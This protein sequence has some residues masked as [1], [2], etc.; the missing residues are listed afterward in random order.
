MQVRFWGTRGSIPSPGSHTVRYGGNTSCVE[1]IAADGTN[2]I[3]DCGTG[4]RELGQQLLSRGP[5]ALRLHLFIGHTH[6]DHIQGFPFFVPAFLPGTELNIYAPAGFQRSLEDSMAGQMQYSYF[7]VRF[8]DLQ[9]RIHFTDLGEGFF[10]VGELLVETLHLNHTV[11]TIAYRITGDGAT[12]AYVTDHE[13][14]WKSDGDR[15]RHPGDLRHIGFLKDAD[16]VIHD[17]QYTEEEYPQRIGWGHSTVEYATDVA[18]AAGA[19]RL[20]LFHH[21]PNR[22]DG[23]IEKLEALARDRVSARGSG[24]EVFA[25]AEGLILDVAGGIGQAP[26]VT[27]LSAL[28]RR[29]IAG[30]RVLVV[31]SIASDV[32]AIIQQLEEDHLVLTRS[33]TLAVALAQARETPPDLVIV[34]ADLPDS[35]GV[36]HIERLRDWSARESLPLLLL[37]EGPNIEL[38]LRAS[39]PAID[40][41]VKPFSPAML[42]ARVRAWL[43]RA[44]DRDDAAASDRGTPAPAWIDIEPSAPDQNGHSVDELANAPMF[45]S[46][47]RGLL[48]RLHERGQEQ[49]FR[50]GQL[51][52]HQGDR[53]DYLF[54]VLY[55]RVRVTEAAEEHRITDLLLGEIGPGEMF[56][57]LGVLTAKPRSAT[58][59]AIEPTRCW[60][61]HR[62]DFMSVLQDSTDLSVGLARTLADRLYDADR[63]L[64]RYAPDPLTGLANRR[65][66]HDQYA[67][68][69]AQ[70]LREDRPLVLLML[71]VLN[72]RGINDQL[73]YEAGDEAL[74][75]VADALMESARRSDIVARYGGDEFAVLLVGGTSKAVDLIID[76]LR[77]S[78]AGLIANRHIPPQLQCSVGVGA[79]PK[80]PESLDELVR[81]ADMDMHREG[82][83]RSIRV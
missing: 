52:I 4:A 5:S 65:V 20:A 27:D 35:S 32:S 21:D 53:S 12:I 55:G 10:R 37:A 74:R 38:A 57:E 26:E 14:F 51:I 80:P 44:I 29:P 56:G 19:R 40:C 48:E 18:I 17:A 43:E 76:R 30:R 45:A 13:P 3:L 34:D 39:E 73:G 23:S 69:A 75:A 7:P 72:L 25:A 1:V 33:G 15:F 66:L 58:V 63:R 28:R 41:L 42:R 61:I 82:P 31:S 50:P 9:S 79:S 78:L 83:R 36:H 16:L 6:W 2:I 71:D 70:A 81:L 67:R 62:E 46:L 77:K 60:V 68:L 24:L 22:D 49:S 47:D 59:T 54:V 8:R 11:P 64:A